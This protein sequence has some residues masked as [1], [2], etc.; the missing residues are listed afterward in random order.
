MGLIAEYLLASEYDVVGLQEVWIRKDFN[1]LAQRLGSKF[2][3]SYSFKRFVPPIC[4][5]SS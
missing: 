3:Y 5:V 4:I 2:P 1:E